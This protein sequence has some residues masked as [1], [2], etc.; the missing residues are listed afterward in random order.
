MREGGRERE[1]GE[2]EREKERERERE[3]ERHRA[4]QQ[5]LV[6]CNS[7]TAHC[8]ALFI[9]F[10]ISRQIYPFIATVKKKKTD[11]ME[12]VKGKGNHY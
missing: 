12:S 6:M 5:L 2:K 9:L 11:V 1:Q 4:G 7:E 3:R 10:T 8:E